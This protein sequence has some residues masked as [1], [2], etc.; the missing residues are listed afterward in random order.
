[1][2]G[3]GVAVLMP[4]NGHA[5]SS[6]RSV[7]RSEPGRA[8][9]SLRVD[10]S[11]T[12]ISPERAGRPD[13]AAGRIRQV[14][15]EAF[16]GVVAFGRGSAFG[17]ALTGKSGG[18]AFVQGENWPVRA[19]RRTLSLRRRHPSR[20]PMGTFSPRL[21]I[22]PEAQ[23]QL[24]AELRDVP[25]DFVLYGG[26]AV[27][28]HLGHRQSIDFDFFGRGAVEP[29]RLAREIPF[30]ADATFI[31]AEPDAISAIVHRGEGVKVSFYRLETLRPLR[32]PHIAEETGLRVASLLDLAGMKA[33]VVLQ[34]AEAKDYL[35]IDALIS[36]GG[37]DL[38]AA[39]A[40]ASAL[41]GRAYSPL[42]TLK[43]LSY[44]EDGDLPGLPAGVKTR[45][46]AAARRV[47]LNRLPRLRDAPGDVERSRDRDR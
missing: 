4:C 12:G 25:P 19:V 7:S 43:A 23:R 20:P 38:E 29:S 1:M 3:R 35:D 44:F 15:F 46:A 21:D 31:Q 42:S 9:P 34:R 5:A 2:I 27:A 33:K 30:M 6:A 32:A 28:L 22:L 10:A 14:A 41:F 18:L 40:S 24:W 16:V 8:K 26:T 36:Q 39:L 13:H 45:L 11:G 47:D 37:V 17:N